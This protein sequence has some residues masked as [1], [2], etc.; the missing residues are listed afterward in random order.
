VPKGGDGNARNVL[1]TLRS[2]QVSVGSDG[3][4]R[5]VHHR[6]EKW[7]AVRPLRHQIPVRGLK[8]KF[9]LD[10]VPP[11]EPRYNVSPRCTADRQSA[12][13]PAW[14]FAAPE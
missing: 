7:R 13:A 4:C 11:F 5:R 14:L 12:F 9:H 8:V 2:V 3:F 6:E 10:E 1:N